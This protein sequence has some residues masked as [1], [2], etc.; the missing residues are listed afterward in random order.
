LLPSCNFVFLKKNPFLLKSLLF[1]IVIFSILVCSSCKEVG[2]TDADAENYEPAAKKDCNCCI[3]N[4]RIKLWYGDA[5]YNNYLGGSK[6]SS[7]NVLWCYLNGVYVNKTMK[8]LGNSDYRSPYI[9]S[10]NGAFSYISYGNQDVLALELD[11]KQSKQVRCEL[12][13]LLNNSTLVW[14]DTVTFKAKTVIPVELK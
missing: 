13:V 2:C 9:V 11:L 7:T 10:G 14:K 3:Y 12:K 1:I 5:F 4:G 6:A 8:G